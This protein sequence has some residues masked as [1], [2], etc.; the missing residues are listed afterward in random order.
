MIRWKNRRRPTRAELIERKHQ[1]EGR[2][3]V[4]VAELIRRTAEA[5]PPTPSKLNSTASETDT[6]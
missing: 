1:L 3:N 6:T 5:N 2:V 4:L